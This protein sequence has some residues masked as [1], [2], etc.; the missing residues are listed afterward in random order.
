MTKKV[1]VELRVRLGLRAGVVTRTR[2]T[3]M[4]SSKGR[5]FGITH[6]YKVVELF[7]NRAF[8]QPMVVRPVIQKG[9]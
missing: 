2:P 1:F 8:V 5:L 4:V 9:N 6:Q 3:S 7:A